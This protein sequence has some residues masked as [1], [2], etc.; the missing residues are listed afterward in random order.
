MARRRF[1]RWF[2][3]FFDQTLSLAV[4]GEILTLPIISEAVLE[5]EVSAR[6]TIVRIIGQLRM[7]QSVGVPEVDLS[8]WGGVATGFAATGFLISN[9]YEDPWLMWTFRWADDTASSSIS[10]SLIEVDVRAK[11]KMLPYTRLDLVA[12]TVNTVVDQDSRLS[13]HLRTLI[14]L[15]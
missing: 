2:D 13:G 9:N 1:T 14:F 7:F 8:I 12:N 15:P 10:Q 4:A 5:D 11:R 3:S 6:S